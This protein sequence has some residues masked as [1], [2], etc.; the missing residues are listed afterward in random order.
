MLLYAIAYLI[1]Y[2]EGA[3]IIVFGLVGIYFLFKG[4]GIDEIFRYFY[5]SLQNSLSHGRFSFVTYIVALLIGLVG[6]LIGFSRILQYYPSEESMG[7]FLIIVTFIYG[8]IGWFMVAGLIISIG[9]IIDSYINEQESLGRVVV[10]PFFIVAIGIIAYGASIYTLS[11]SA[12]P[13]FP[14][15]QAVGLQYLAYTLVGGLLCALIGVYIQSVIRRWQ[16][17]GQTAIYTE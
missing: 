14:Q 15:G 9:K 17:Q 7:L 6:V 16:G 12:I 1:G 8:S 3:T 13:D 10:L 11:M 2:P 5:S 4:F